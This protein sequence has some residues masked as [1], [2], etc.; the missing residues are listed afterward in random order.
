MPKIVHMHTPLAE[1][2][3]RKLQLDDVVYLTGDAY[4]MLY[5]D[6]FSLIMDLLK[7]GEPLPMELRDGVIYNTG[8]IYRKRANGGYDLRAL[9]TTTSSKYNALTPEF[10]K[11]TGIRAILGKGGMDAATLAAM[12]EY[13]CVYLALAG[14]CSAV[15]SP[16]AEIIAD[17]WPELT[18]VDNQ[19]LKFRLKEFGPLLVAMDAN[20]NS[21][22]EQCAD[23][24]RSNLPAI[25]QTLGINTD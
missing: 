24:I 3:I 15:Y 7:R 9:G 2:E 18:P 4:C 8:A 14:G 22:F 23:T 16:A 12:K 25:Y 13:G 17:Y 10:I 21:L 19:R 20:G 5:V 1:K 11:L 6:H